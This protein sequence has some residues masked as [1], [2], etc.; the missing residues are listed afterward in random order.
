MVDD[1][2]FAE[3]SKYTWC[4]T[5]K[6]GKWYAVRGRRKS[7]MPGTVLI[8][9]HR[10]LF[11]SPA[12][13]DIDHRDGDGL[14]NQRANLR[15]C[16]HADN[17]RSHK[18]HQNYGGRSTSSKFKGVWKNPNGRFHAGIV[19]QRKRM[20]LGCFANEEDAAR[21]YDAKARELFGAFAKCNFEVAS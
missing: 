17:Q 14:N 7:E 18:K 1:E 9:M 16:T 8:S 11:G 21:A 2:D 20:H 5:N 15:V 19:N 3:L 12:G 6:R 4:A 10:Q 13:L